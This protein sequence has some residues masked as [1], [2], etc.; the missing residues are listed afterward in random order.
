MTKSEMV[1]RAIDTHIEQLKTLVAYGLGT[2]PD[3][4]VEYGL[5]A[6]KH[7]LEAYRYL[8]A[9]QLRQAKARMAEAQRWRALSEKRR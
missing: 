2:Q 7:E 6:D 9:G 4:R 3:D 8:K 5:K 1:R